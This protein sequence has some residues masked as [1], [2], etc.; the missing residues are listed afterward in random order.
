MP[1]LKVLLALVLTFDCCGPPKTPLLKV[2]LVLSLPF[3]LGLTADGWIVP[4]W[5]PFVP[6]MFES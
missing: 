1:L 2:L 6:K 3:L 4:V 5:A